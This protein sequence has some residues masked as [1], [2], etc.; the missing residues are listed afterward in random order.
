MTADVLIMTFPT[1]KLYQSVHRDEITASIITIFY[2]KD[3]IKTLMFACETSLQ[4]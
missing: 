3:N 1:W 4:I 2:I